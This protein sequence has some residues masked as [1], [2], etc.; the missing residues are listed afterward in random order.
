MNGRLLYLAVLA[1]ACILSSHANSA[2]LTVGPPGATTGCSHPTLQAAIDAAAASPGLDIIRIARG[3]YPAQHLVINDSGSLAIEGGF[4]SCQTL[5]YYDNSTLDGQYASPP[6]PVIEDRGAG[7]LTL[8]HLH[9]QN[10]NATGTGATVTS[11]GGVAALGKGLL[12]IKNSVISNNRGI[13]G[14]GLYLGNARQSRQQLDLLGVEFY[15]NH[16]N[17][18]GG[19][20]Y[21]DFADIKIKGEVPSVFQGNRAEGTTDYNGG[22]AIFAL[23]SDISVN[24]RM[25]PALAFMDS[26][27]TTA[28]GGAIYFQSTLPQ[29]SWLSIAAEPGGGGPQIIYNTA[30]F[31][32]GGI[33]AYASEIGANAH[34]VLHDTVL[35]H[36]TSPSGSALEMYANGNA[37]SLVNIA[38]VADP[39][40]RICA[41]SERCNRISNNVSNGYGTIVGITGGPG[42]GQT[43]FQLDRGHIIDNSSIHLGGVFDGTNPGN[44]V[45]IRNSVIAENDSGGSSLFNLTASSLL[46]NVTI[47]NNQ[48]VTPAVIRAYGAT[49]ELYKSV[50]FQPS[51]ALTNVGASGSVLLRNLMLASG[52]PPVGNEGPR[53][54]MYVADPY[55]VNSGA[56]DY[57][58]QVGSQARNRYGTNDGIALPTVDLLGALRP[59]PGE[60]PAYAYDLGAYEYGAVIDSIF[61]DD[62]DN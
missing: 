52:M 40:N 14:G 51:A 23:D 46:E 47:A 16:A 10:G 45:W 54:I 48:R 5:V 24:V 30:S 19:A 15:N 21:T 43:R 58:V 6:G 12:T 61:I 39:N 62:F 44:S 49:A 27:T 36:N 57:R 4:V 22:G 1:T 8:D 32:G 20:L 41:A 28:N 26:N 34:I 11:G 31:T 53:S 60:D 29:G 42:K 7:N 37:Q 25:S 13:Y 38:M 59:A 18:S 17:L 2:V 33:F 55:F 50:V 35:D 3:L 56:G 9:I